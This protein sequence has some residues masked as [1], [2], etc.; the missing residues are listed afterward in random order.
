M[1]PREEAAPNRGESPGADL[2]GSPLYPKAFHFTMTGLLEF[3]VLIGILF[4]TLW[5]L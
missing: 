3:L 1:A 2:P 5:A 4:A